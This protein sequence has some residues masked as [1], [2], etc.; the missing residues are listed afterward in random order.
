M[1]VSQQ[2]RFVLTLALLAV[3]AVGGTLAKGQEDKKDEK[4]AKDG[5]ILVYFKVFDANDPKS[6]PLKLTGKAVLSV[7]NQATKKTQFKGDVPVT[8]P[9]ME[10]DDKTHKDFYSVELD[11]G[12]LVEHLIIFVQGTKY[13]PADMV[14]IVTKDQMTLYP[15]ASSSLDRFGFT[16]YMN[17]LNTYRAIMTDLLDEFPAERTQIRQVLSAAFRTQLTNM[18]QAAD[19]RP[20]QVAPNENIRL[21][22]DDA[23]EIAAA[24]KLADDVLKLYGLRAPDAPAP[25]EKHEERFEGACDPECEP[26]I[27]CPCPRRGFFRRIRGH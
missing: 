3:S 22:T 8:G 11:K 26:W 4:K 21:L 9:I 16:A 19:E 18:A 24:R 2:V 17:Q 12:D 23:G 10:A 15:G 13:S 27:D 14:K 7:R 6:D 5:K 1:N 20:N 25:G